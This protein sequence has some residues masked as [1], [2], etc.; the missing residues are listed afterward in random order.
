VE[1]NL[2]ELSYDKILLAKYAYIDTLEIIIA[3][4]HLSH[5]T[6]SINYV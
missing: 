1:T 4:Y 3:N 5:H 2:G 6:D